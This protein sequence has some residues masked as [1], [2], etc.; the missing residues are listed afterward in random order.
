LYRPEQ[1]E[2]ANIRRVLSDLGVVLR[3]I[4]KAPE[5]K[6]SGMI[7]RLAPAP[8]VAAAGMRLMT[9]VGA[10]ATPRTDMERTVAGIWQELFDNPGVS[11]EANF[12]DLGGHSLLAISMAS[13]CRKVF[14]L[15]DPVREIFESPT[16]AELAEVIERGLKSQGRKPGDG[17]DGTPRQRSSALGR[18]VFPLSYQQEQLWFLDQFQ[19]GSDFYNV[20]LAWKLTGDLDVP[21]LE[22]SL[23]EVVRRHEQLRTCFVMEHEEP[24]QKVVEATFDV[25]LPVVDLRQLE[26]GERE[27]QAKKVVAEE[28]DKAFELSQAPLLRGVLVRTNEREH[29]LG[30]T[31]HH[32][33]CDDWSLGLLT[34]E[35]GKLYEASG[36]GEKRGCRI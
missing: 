18:S 11:L 21:T 35:L 13:S 26:P 1:F 29:V 16:I 3:E 15:D 28:A 24:R 17:K 32:I 4:A 12:F 8:A 31:L 14:G 9:A 30:P 25:R 19:P 36:R 34:K 10:E 27:E 33:I 2:A 7:S 6:L 22:R 23:R 5:A 20:P